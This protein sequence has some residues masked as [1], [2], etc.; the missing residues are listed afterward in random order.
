MANNKWDV[1]ANYD[2]DTDGMLRV[3]SSTHC[4]TEYGYGIYVRATHNSCVL[5]WERV[6]F[7]AD[8]QTRRSAGR[9]VRA[10]A[11]Y[12]LKQ[13]GYGYANGVWSL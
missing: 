3:R 6:A 11:R 13:D 7:D 12:A 4:P 8:E 1:M 9:R 10:R 5:A 2:P